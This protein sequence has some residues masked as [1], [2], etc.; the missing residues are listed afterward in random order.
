VLILGG[1]L[2]AAIFTRQ[3]MSLLY[4]AIALFLAGMLLS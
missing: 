4:T 2:L 1:S 3:E